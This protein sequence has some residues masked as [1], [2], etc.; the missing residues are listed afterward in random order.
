MRCQDC[1]YGFVS[2]LASDR[3]K[4]RR[5]HDRLLF[6][7]KRRAITEVHAVWQADAGAVRVVNARSPL[8]HR[9]IAEEVSL[10]AAG[11]VDFS[12][13]AFSAVE[14][15]SERDYHI[16]LGTQLERAVCYIMLERR[17]HVWRCTWTEYDSRTVHEVSD[18][19]SVWSVSFAWVS[20]AKRRQGWAR[21]SL[22][23]ATQYLDF[24]WAHLGWHTPFSP[25]G[26]ALARHL[27]PDGILI[28]K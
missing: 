8:A 23:A 21:R 11:E 19:G 25:A 24:P 7:L 14:Q 2:E 27:C 28:A 10:I 4:H 13:V 1:D 17:S 18:L 6:G 5:Y 20:R 3:R 15:E 26:E 9:R 12:F 16:F 22:E